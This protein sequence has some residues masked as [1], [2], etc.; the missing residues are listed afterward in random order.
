MSTN[1]QGAPP[2]NNV[3]KTIK[4]NNIKD[5][6]I[7][8]NL[9]EKNSFID[10]NNTKEEEL[11]NP[12][13]KSNEIRGN[14]SD[15]FGN[16]MIN[17]I[18]NLFLRPNFILNG[19]SYFFYPKEIK[20]ELESELE[21][22]FKRYPEMF[23]YIKKDLKEFSKKK[24]EKE[25]VENI[26]FINSIKYHLFSIF[27]PSKFNEIEKRKAKDVAFLL[28]Q[29]NGKNQ[30]MEKDKCYILYLDKN[31]WKFK[32]DEDNYFKYIKQNLP[33]ESLNQDDN[34]YVQNLY[35]TMKKIK[36]EILN[37][38]TE[39]DI[40]KKKILINYLVIL[41]VKEIIQIKHSYRKEQLNN[42]AK[43]ILG[44]IEDEINLLFIKYNYFE[45]KEKKNF[46]MI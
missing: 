29:I 45:K 42:E 8:D 40:S 34:I 4:I 31:N 25:F 26:G 30:E 15:L 46:F 39:N 43:I 22:A 32:F 17:P 33:K 10:K 3:N 2:A 7:E 24:Q 14:F 11:I 28:S 21:E 36:D 20:D 13:I 12:N 44:K 5:R 6:A 38:N 27:Y 37:N 18:E 23:K 1:I 9:E 35:E 19:K 41:I 16:I